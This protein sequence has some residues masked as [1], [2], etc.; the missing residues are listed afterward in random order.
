MS[1]KLNY[2]TVKCAH[3]M[4]SKKAANIV[5]A[6][7]L[8]GML[9]IVLSD[10][11]F[12]S[13]QK[14]THSVE[15]TESGDTLRQYV[16]TLETRTEK[17]LLSIDGAGQCRVMITA[18]ASR[19]QEFAVDRNQT[20]DTDSSRQKSQ[21]ETQIVMFENNNGKKNAL[22]RRVLEPKIRGVLILCEGAERPVVAERVTQAAKTLLG[23]SANK[24]CVTK[25]KNDEKEIG[26]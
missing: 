8:L 19:E 24:I 23:V 25:L 21:Q 2:F 17:M 12:V 14:K 5:L 20:Q 3:F 11:I 1:E 18:E 16:E 22:V 4:K 13:G 6:L 7:G 26:K 15:N 9:L 10:R